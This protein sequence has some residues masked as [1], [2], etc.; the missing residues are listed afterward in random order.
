MNNRYMAHEDYHLG[1]PSIYIE[2][3]ET[4]LLNDKIIR[5]EKMNEQDK[6]IKQFKNK[7]NSLTATD[8]HKIK[9]DESWILGET[10]DIELSDTDMCIEDDD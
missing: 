6:E 5:A 4:R 3:T 8:K 9:Y 7:I 2:D 1:S 10:N